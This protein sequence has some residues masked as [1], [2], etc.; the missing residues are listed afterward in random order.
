MTSSISPFHRRHVEKHL[1]RVH[2]VR[3]LH[4]VGQDGHDADHAG[5]HDAE[6]R[7]EGI[8]LDVSDR[9]EADAGQEHEQREH[10]GGRRELLA[11]EHPL[12]HD[13]ARRHQ[14]L[15]HLVERH[16]VVAQAQVLESHR[17]GVEQGEVKV[18]PQRHLLVLN[19]LELARCPQRGG[20]EDHVPAREGHREGEAVGGEERLVEEHDEHRREDGRAHASGNLRAEAREIRDVPRFASHRERSV[21]ER[22]DLSLGLPRAKYKMFNKISSLQLGSSAKS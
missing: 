18:R 21:L 16:A 4:G 1:E 7:P 12:D 22:G 13:G 5:G 10:D 17:H 2:V 14:E 20:G 3:L 6:E 8:E 9:G 15:A 19:H 11:E